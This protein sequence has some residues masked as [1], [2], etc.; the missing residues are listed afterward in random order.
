MQG[1]Y[2]T[3]YYSKIIRLLWQHIHAAQRG[4][5]RS[6][7]TA[8]FSISSF[9]PINVPCFFPLSSSS[10]E[11]VDRQLA[12]LN[13]PSHLASDTVFMF[14]N[15]EVFL[16]SRA[17]L[18]IQC[19]E[20]TPV[21]YSREGRHMETAVCLSGLFP[22]TRECI[23][24]GRISQMPVSVSDVLREWQKRRLRVLT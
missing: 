5:L 24:A 4:T 7:I 14:P 20:M 10:P 23:V 3:Q 13:S 22:T 9:L 11:V 6:S 16:A 17:I 12:S 15:G 2:F 8:V 1:E 19:N 21:L 18:S